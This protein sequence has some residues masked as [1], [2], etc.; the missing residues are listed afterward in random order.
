M[1]STPSFPPQ[2]AAILWD[3][4]G[5][6]V[7]T[8][9]LHYESWSQVLRA[10]GQDLSW[11]QFL[12]TLGMNNRST[13]RELFGREPLEEEIA[14]I[15][16]EKEVIFRDSLAGRVQPLPGVQRWLERFRA[17]G[18]PQAVASSAPLENI[19]ALVDALQIRP[20]FTALVSG[21]DL[22]G[23]PN[24]DV[25]LLAARQLGIP[26]ARALVI[27]DSIAGVSAARSAGMRCLAVLTSN[28]AS[29]LS[30]ADCILPDLDA[31]DESLALALL[32][33]HP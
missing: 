33:P 18:I 26:P 11:P 15:A 13:M 23:K 12:P 31:L 17:W 7:D 16:G 30:L 27:E 4:D 25:F 32:N 3:M 10:R 22:P 14:S 6:L 5:V 20:Y 24:P 21:M 28:P 8:G 2:S 9:R 1:P 19:D 29:A